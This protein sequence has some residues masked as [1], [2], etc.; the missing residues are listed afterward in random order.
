LVEA[1]GRSAVVS[2]SF[3][4]DIPENHLE[5]EKRKKNYS[6]RQLDDELLLIHRI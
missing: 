4:D 6:L 3:G 5:E 2:E 1:L